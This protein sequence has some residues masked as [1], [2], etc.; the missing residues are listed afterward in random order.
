MKDQEKYWEPEESVFQTMH[1]TQ[2]VQ[3][4][5]VEINVKI[6]V[7]E[8][9]AAYYVETKKSGVKITPVKIDDP[10]VLCNLKNVKTRGQF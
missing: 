2:V 5:T 8:I 3:I 1:F 4:E 6:V 10:S 7:F 9:P